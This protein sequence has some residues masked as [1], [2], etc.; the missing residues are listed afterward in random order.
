MADRTI[1]K[2]DM[3]AA[4]EQAEKKYPNLPKGLLREMAQV[5]SAYGTKLSNPSGARGPWQFM[6][7]TGP[8]Y[9]L[10][11]E[12]D[13][14][15]P[16]KSA[17]AAARLMLDNKRVLEKKLGR[18]VSNGELYLAH[19]QGATGASKLLLNPNALAKDVVGASAVKQNLPASQRD[20]FDK[21]TTGEFAALWTNKFGGSP[22]TAT[23]A[24]PAKKSNPL[25]ASP[26][27][28]LPGVTPAS[29]FYDY[30]PNSLT[31]LQ[32][33]G[34]E[35]V[36]KT[37]MLKGVP[38][39]LTA[40]PKTKG[41]ASQLFAPADS[42]PAANPETAPEPAPAA[43]RDIAILKGLSTLDKVAQ[44]NAVA[45]RTVEGVEPTRVA[46]S[47]T[48][49]DFTAGV[50][51]GMANME[52]DLEYFGAIVDT[53]TGN[54][55]GAQSHLVN[56]DIQSENA[57]QA[58]SGMQS[59]DEFLKAP[60]IDGFLQQAVSSAGQVAPSALESMAWALVTGGT[61]A[62]GKTALSQGSKAVAKTLV[63]D[64]LEKKA[65]GEILDKAENA[66][67]DT[68][69]D[70]MKKG[71]LAGAFGQEFVHGAGAAFSE[72]D[73]AGVSLDAEHALQSLLI[74]V[75]QA[76]VGA[77][78]EKFI[79]ETLGKL[80]LKKTT[81][82]AGDSVLK[83]FA[84]DVGGAAVKSAAMEGGTE[85]IQEGIS[86]LQ[87]T[88]VDPEYSKEDAQLRLAQ[89]AFAGAFG[90]GL[91]GGAGAIPAA[92]LA[93][94]RRETLGKE[95][96]DK[97]RGYV[98]DAADARV[99]TQVNQ[100]TKGVDD[101]ALT[102]D[103]A[104][105]SPQ[106]LGAQFADM[107][108][109]DHPREAMWV[110]ENQPLNGIEIAPGKV[111][112]HVMQDDT[113]RGQSIFIGN[114]PGRGNIISRSKARVDAV[115][116]A[117]N[118]G[119]DVDPVV[120]K[121]LGMGP[122]GDQVIRAKNAEGTVVHEQMFNE[123]D[124]AAAE[125]TAAAHAG[126]NGTVD[127]PSVGTALEERAQAFAAGRD[128]IQDV[129]KFMSGMVD[130]LSDEEMQKKLDEEAAA[131]KKAKEEEP[132]VRD[133]R[134]DSPQGDALKADAVKSLSEDPTYENVKRVRNLLRKEAADSL[135]EPKPAPRKDLS[136]KEI[137]DAFD[138]VEREAKKRT[139]LI[140]RVVPLLNDAI[141]A[142]EI[143]QETP[144]GS[145][146]D[147]KRVVDRRLKSAIAALS[148]DVQVRDM[149][150]DEEGDTTGDGE[151]STE[152]D[153]TDIEQRLAERYAEIDD[154]HAEV[155]ESYNPEKR[156]R[157]SEEAKKFYFQFTEMLD[158]IPP[159]MR[160]VADK[161]SEY[162]DIM[163][164]SMLNK[165][166]KLIE[167]NPESVFD[168]RQNDAG[169]LE[170]VRRDNSTD[171]ETIETRK[172]VRDTLSMVADMSGKADENGV[173]FV[174]G[175][176][177]V[178]GFHER[179]DKKT[180]KTYMHEG[181]PSKFSLLRTNPE[182]RAKFESPTS[183]PVEGVVTDE[184]KAELKAFNER[185]A[186]SKKG[187]NKYLNLAGWKSA[188]GQGLG[189]PGLM[190]LAQAGVAL[191]AKINRGLDGPKYTPQQKLRLG[192]ETMVG[193]LLDAGYQLVYEPGEGQAPIPVTDFK[194][195][196]GDA[197]FELAA[198]IAGRPYTLG[199][200]FGG[201][202]PLDLTEDFDPAAMPDQL[203]NTMENTTKSKMVT[204]DGEKRIVADAKAV[205]RDTGQPV[206]TAVDQNEE[207]ALADARK[208]RQGGFVE[209][210]T[211]SN[212]RDQAKREA[213]QAV[214]S[215]GMERGLPE[216]VED[217]LDD[218]PEDVV[219]KL[220]KVNGA[221]VA[222][223]TSPRFPEA[224]VE[225]KRV[226]WAVA[227]AHAI[228]NGQP[229]SAK[230][231]YN[232]IS[233]E[234]A[235][236]STL[237]SQSNAD[238]DLAKSKAPE[239]TG[240]RALKDQTSLKETATGDKYKQV[241]EFK[242]HGKMGTITQRIAD[243]AMRKFL[244][245]R[246]VDIMTLEHL[247]ANF[248]KLVSGEFKGFHN[249][250]ADTIG[251]MNAPDSKA[252]HGRVI[253][254]DRSLIILRHS[255]EKELKANGDEAFSS[256]D[257]FVGSVLA[258]ELGHIIFNQEFDLIAERENK[259]KLWEAF[260][261]FRAEMDV[262]PSDYQHTKEQVAEELARRKTAAGRSFA[263]RESSRDAFGEEETIDRWEKEYRA[264]EKEVEQDYNKRDFEEWFS[265][266]VM[267]YV[268]NEAKPAKNATDS[269]FKR[270][271]RAFKDF[272][273][274]VNRVLKGRLKTA[275]LKGVDK[276]T[277][278]TKVVWEFGDFMEKIVAEHDLQRKE[279]NQ[280]PM[281]AKIKIREM[282][283]NLAGR[284]PAGAVSRMATAGRRIMSTGKWGDIMHKVQNLV[285]AS[286]D[287][288]K[289]DEHGPGGKALAKFFGTLSQSTD[290]MGWNKLKLFE[291]NRLNN[292]FAKI[293]GFTQK[294]SHKE[295]ESPRVTAI[296]NEA[297]D[298]T[299]PTANLSTPEAKAVR[300][301]FEKLFDNYIVDP[302][303]G[304]PRIKI[305]KMENYGGPRMFNA[306]K[307]AANREQFIQWLM[308]HPTWRN[309]PNA[310]AAAESVADRITV[311]TG[312]I[313]K[314]V[315][316]E[317][318]NDISNGV[319]PNTP[320]VRARELFL[321][322]MTDRAIATLRNKVI[323][324]AKK[325]NGYNMDDLHRALKTT[326]PPAQP[327]EVMPRY[328]RKARNRLHARLMSQRY[329][330]QEAVIKRFWSDM[331]Q[332]LRLTPGM[333][334][335]LERNRN[336][337][338]IGTADFRNATPD[339]PNGWLVPQGKAISQYFHFVTRMI[340]YEKLGGY[341]FVRDQLDKV[342]EQHR[343]D[344][345]DAIMANL[346]KFSESMS[347]KWRAF[348]SVTA[349][350]TVFTTLLFT[351][352]IS[353]TDIAGVASRSK[354]FNNLGNFFK[355]MQAAL[356]DDEWKELALSVGTVTLRAQDHAMVGLGEL[357]Y[358]NQASRSLMNGF[359][360]FTG[361]EFFTRFSRTFA[362]GMGREFLVNTANKASFG[363]REERYLA[364]LGLTRDDVLTWVANGQDFESP[365]GERVRDAIARFADE[366]I[367]RPDA[368]QR[369]TW[370]SN[371]Y[372]QMIW[373]LKSYYYGF[374]KTIMGGLGREI[375]NRASE[376]G[377]FVDAAGPALLLAATIIPLTMLGMASRDWMRWLFQMALPGV[378]ETPFRTSQMNPGEYA[379]DVFQR[380]GVLG[381]WAI[382][383]N[384]MEALQFEGIAAPFT[385]N[386]P[387]ADLVDDFV[388]DGDLT[389]PVPVLNNVK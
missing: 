346:G 317:V 362:T 315:T 33:G 93:A 46:P 94:T 151:T 239:A 152:A 140:E 284:I 9:G 69:F 386:I 280:L 267:A 314:N 226:E 320:V 336:I 356:T 79:L 194:R 374:G 84:A 389:R 289:L 131:A 170:I 269:F 149:T 22:S 179:T 369:P 272:Y 82:E 187:K 214:V 195:L 193:A 150:V 270:L 358:A 92:G 91:F 196:K 219:I 376:N 90:G 129:H 250:L 54:E 25:A 35:L 360:R 345:D 122:K 184:Q 333:D 119:E 139:T 77:G 290:K 205:T 367:I 183:T 102:G 55:K 349:V 230:V 1:S 13:R 202:L 328:E 96:V 326:F 117:H 335:A 15:D 312:D 273:Y 189:R 128:E 365:Q 98:K 174:Q 191:N 124:R 363:A 348:N 388:F 132:K 260:T 247:E 160:D 261:K 17:D 288:M 381:P 175:G 350:W 164:K 296:L 308:A 167:R 364:E 155:I 100:D 200:L 24:P 213:L 331:T 286:T 88:M 257:A 201:K 266:Q 137:H 353:V 215:E 56:A 283:A 47:G 78:S 173:W 344:I 45:A 291:E 70:R 29:D 21:L 242:L 168:I 271:A 42:M 27:G 293:F 39:E 324:D 377:E 351:A 361:L 83:R 171:P 379:W 243:A 60:T 31:Q 274:E 36:R 125:A 237:D 169:Q 72:F 116:A 109:N 209:E 263:A 268:Y 227:R 207:R 251:R 371:P 51:A 118:A 254:G 228:A 339:D 103:T 62:L 115:M 285:Q 372:F 359:F 292:E 306:Q 141:D 180:R 26:L 111:V 157:G 221:W 165:L 368:S 244:F 181:S 71:A 154:A 95:I 341:S 229:D 375:K 6:P 234:H 342:P 12:E 246:P 127:Q 216:L 373:Q 143:M 81:R 321:R 20:K 309:R 313:V 387:M 265:D 30:N 203:E 28:A 255:I 323:D 329:D 299:I 282:R 208:K 223:V 63:K 238:G 304:K 44:R 80:A 232:R 197:R 262:V 58:L 108:N 59:F 222:T 153:M 104:P 64:M 147:L 32:R 106:V 298:N 110:A 53:L 355:N 41:F 85:T 347:P 123:E 162:E 87:R 112:E 89:A 305:N 334:P 66:L 130:S 172:A 311:H 322:S 5:E 338:S 178:R 190:A 240:S 343:Q 327:G 383:L 188:S 145:N 325:Q 136:T 121:M 146:N 318:D 275:T 120:G 185:S 217:A 43:K 97:A 287:F 253:M 340:E 310:R 4:I 248:D 133:M 161:F 256:D 277:S 378:P 61:Y 49:G 38:R 48:V 212:E 144:D 235:F 245:K 264:S 241:N 279:S 57:A 23:E 126:P 163:S 86:V 2:A 74:G 67:L 50:D 319:F 302:A 192:F 236:S 211:Q 300:A 295:W 186:K 297:E 384:T 14:M 75:P 10:A 354:E 19:Q 278:E 249:Q 52:G 18:P 134:I 166:S 11:T 113:Y 177:L 380:S 65:K 158:K 258:H 105:E 252:P 182:Q 224:K 352:L 225:S 307:I 68:M 138:S 3:D 156:E 357:D 316:A 276:V 114:V 99:E 259:L 7:A 330:E 206:R 231:Q 37:Q 40:V 366:A 8:Q 210:I 233:L 101:G 142:Y 34:Q 16:Y 220:K 332:A 148:P 159:H 303:T 135:N 76:V 301:L 281:E 294:T 218:I 107:F 73:D 199:E 385:A 204:V 382:A 370:A 198:V 337:E 176:K